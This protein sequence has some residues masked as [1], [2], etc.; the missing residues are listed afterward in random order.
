MSADVGIEKLRKQL[1]CPLCLDICEKP[2]I[3]SCSHEA[4]LDCL[5]QCIKREEV[6]EKGLVQVIECPEC[7]TVTVL[8][9]KDVSQLQTAFKTNNLIDVYNDLLKSSSSQEDEKKTSNNNITKE[10][11]STHPD[12]YLEFWCKDCEELICSHCEV[13]GAKHAKHTH[14]LL[15]KEY[16]TEK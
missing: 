1:S 12:Q 3:L 7:R 8:G 14:S 15:S 5:T 6:Q 13:E 16:H 11:C 9:D 2:K 4:C 10:V